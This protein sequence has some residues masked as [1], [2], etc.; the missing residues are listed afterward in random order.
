[1]RPA[2]ILVQRMEKEEALE[3]EQ[4]MWHADLAL[5]LAWFIPILLGVLLAFI[6]MHFS[7]EDSERAERRENAANAPVW[8]P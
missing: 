8:H 6:L 3:K 2:G 4:A 7:D 5:A 1:M